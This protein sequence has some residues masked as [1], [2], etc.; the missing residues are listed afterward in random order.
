MQIYR[1]MDRITQAPSEEITG[2]VRHYFVRCV[3]PREEY[4]VAQFV[5]E[6]QEVIK[7]II[8]RGKFPLV[9]GG[10]GLYMKTL[11]DGIF[12]S[13]PKDEQLRKSFE[14]IEKE[15]GPGFL[16]R[17][18][19]AIDPETAKKLH[20]NDM[21]R[22][23]RALEVRELTGKTIH[24]K[25]KEIEGIKEKYSCRIFALDLAR[26]ELYDRI[27]KSVDAM[28]MNGIVDAVGEIK[29]TE[30]GMTARKAIGIKEISEYLAG[31]VDM[32]TAREE[33][34]MNTRRYAKR[35]LT[36][37][38]AEERA[39]WVRADRPVSEIVDEIIVRLKTK[40]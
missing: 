15:K 40:G 20:P 28:F 36:W 7:D 39:E 27:N 8:S 38:R 1:G 6:A 24:D 32:D 31:K 3:D 19:L 37:L 10:T 23:I 17:R 2:K 18:L 4:N 26:K 33:M 25:K 35:Q 5:L 22:I 13:P 30:L 34:K 29:K 11:I 21:R 14:E 16:H 12:A 9:T